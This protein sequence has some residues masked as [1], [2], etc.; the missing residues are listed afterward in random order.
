MK[1]VIIFII[2]WLITS[3]LPIILMVESGFAESNFWAYLFICALLGIASS[4]IDEFI[5]DVWD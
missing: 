3:L 4:S 2:A 5:N 1:K